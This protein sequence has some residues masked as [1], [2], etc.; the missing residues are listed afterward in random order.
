M[1]CFSIAHHQSKIL[2]GKVAKKAPLA[3]PGPNT[4][5]RRPR[6]PRKST[7]SDTLPQHAQTDQTPHLPKPVRPKLLTVTAVAVFLFS[8]YGSYLYVTYRNAIESSRKMEVP[9]DV[10][11]RYHKTAPTYDA[12]VDLAEKIM[13]LG[14]RRKEIVQMARGNVLEVSAGTGRNMEHYQLGERRGVDKDGKAEIQGCRSVTFVDQSGEMLDIAKSKFAQSHPDFKQV[15]FR[16]QDAMQPIDSLPS[17]PSTPSS[18]IHPPL[19]FDTVIQTMGLCSHPDPVSLL[20]RL[21]SVTEPERGR[22]LLL[23]HGRSYY[24]WV[25]RLL[26]DLAPAH[27]DRHGCWWNRD[28][29]EIVRMSGLEVVES[30]RFHL[31]TTWKFVLRPREGKDILSATPD[32]EKGKTSK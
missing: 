15:V 11:D 23:E 1:R 2:P 30:K 27:A 28:I 26:D 5:L 29:G 18:P 22:I 14:K 25:N 24:G 17:C 7:P 3:P 4:L 6:A 20:M 12:D 31:G 19:K 8:T 16:A 32:E 13:R 10:S 9:T 21:A